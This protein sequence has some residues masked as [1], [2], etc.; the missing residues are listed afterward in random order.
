MRFLIALLPVLVAVPAQAQL[1]TDLKGYSVG[2][3]VGPETLK[4]CKASALS[5]V[6]PAD[7]DPTAVTLDVTSNV[8]WRV[9]HRFNYA[10]DVKNLLQSISESYSLK[11][12]RI[13]KTSFDLVN[14]LWTR[15][16]KIR[17]ELVSNGPTYYLTVENRAIP[18]ARSKASRDDAKSIAPPRF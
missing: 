3:T 18:D 9:G 12:P 14:Y 1:R 7:G 8:I 16:D 2:E 6:C 17:F 11:K 15:S 13:R 5:H 4:D 10:G